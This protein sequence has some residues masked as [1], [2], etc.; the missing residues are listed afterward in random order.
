MVALKFEGVDIQ[1]AEGQTVLAA[2]ENAGIAIDNACRAGVCQSCLVRSLDAP[3]PAAAQAGLP[4][5]MAMDGY[6]MACVCVPE[7]PLTIGRAGEARQRIETTV[8]AIEPLSPTVVRLS[9]E[10]QGRFACRPGQFLSLI[11]PASGL[12]RSYSIAGK[13]DGAVE[14]HLRLLPGGAMSGLVAERLAPGDTMIIAGPSGTCVYDPAEPDRR[15]VLAGTGTGLAPL[16]GILQDALASG[17][18]G[19]ISLYHGALDRTGLYLVDELEALQ[20]SRPGFRYTPCLR[21]EPGPAGGDLQ[22]VVSALETDLANTTFFLCGDELLI[23]RMKR[24]L[25]L[26]GAKLDRIFADPFT[27]AQSPVRSGAAA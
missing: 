2:L 10:D 26:A 1:A 4:K 19:P 9:L 15:L 27:P 20:R 18:R 12:T 25:F 5:A 21:D 7:G 24:G 6:F 8:R 11:D 14:L 22:A 17:H 23:N 13:A 16:W 3:P